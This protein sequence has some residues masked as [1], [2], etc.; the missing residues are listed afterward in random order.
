MAK[1]DELKNQS[2]LL[3]EQITTHENKIQKLLNNPKASVEGTQEF[4]K[5][6]FLESQQATMKKELQKVK[7]KLAPKPQESA[8]EQV[9]QESTPVKVKRP[10]N[11]LPFE[12]TS[13][14]K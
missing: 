6:G 8:L 13:Q 1:K 7:Q 4:K 14:K 12:I 3:R 9:P 11:S 10:T 5:L 2:K